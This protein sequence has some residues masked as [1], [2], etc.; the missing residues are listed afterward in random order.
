MKVVVAVKQ[1][2]VLGDEVELLADGS[3]ADPDFVDRALNEWDAYAVE[4][5]L[6]LRE[7]EGGE[8][9]AVTLGDEDSEGA[10]RRAL[11]MGADRAVRVDGDELDPL[12]TARSLA[13]VV[14]REEP[15]LVLCGVQSSDSVQGATGAAI[16]GLLGLP[17]VAVVERL[18]WEGG[19]TAVAHR[20]LEGGLAD[21]VELDLPA[22]LTIQ[23]GTN[24][25][26]Y[27]NLRAIKQAE[28][29]EIQLVEAEGGEPGYRLRRMF[30]P[31]RTAGAEM[32]GGGAAEIAEQVATLIR[33]RL[34]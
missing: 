8:V 18:D 33:E 23:T 9:V 6:R 13:A 27:A 34:G 31:P 25:P 24:Q 3:G 2:K 1:V 26:R 10:L 17:C 22:V 32:F 30:V 19:R 29:Q 16:A 12:T 7:R 11:A 4:E 20:E 15:D 28:R 21:V 14:A 5:A